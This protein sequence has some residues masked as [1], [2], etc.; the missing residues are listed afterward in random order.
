MS[1]RHLAFLPAAALALAFAFPAEDLLL[2][3]PAEPTSPSAG[4]E[5][6]SAGPAAFPVQTWTLPGPGGDWG[7]VGF[8]QTTDWAR[9]SE[10]RFGSRHLSFGFSIYAVAGFVACTFLAVVGF[11]MLAVRRES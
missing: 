11:A 10:V 2:N 3:R 9:S 6:V 8:N 7:L 1:S 4:I 5:I